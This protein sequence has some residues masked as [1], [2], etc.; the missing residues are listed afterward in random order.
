M[1]FEESHQED[2]DK[3]KHADQMISERNIR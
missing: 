1:V 3:K 2:F